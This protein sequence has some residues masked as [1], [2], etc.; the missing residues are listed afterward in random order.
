MRACRQPWMPAPGSRSRVAAIGAQAQRRRT[1]ATVIAQRRIS[2]PRRR[3]HRLPHRA[4]RQDRSPAAVPMPTPFGTLYTSNI[5]PDPQT[6]IG[7]WTADEFYQIMHNG[8]FPDGGLIYPAMPFALLHQGDA[9]GQRRDLRL[10][11]LDPAGEAEEPAARSAFPFNNRSLSSAGARCSSRRASTSPTRP[12]RR[13]G[14]AAPIWSRAS[15]IAAC[16]IPPINALGGSSESQAFEGGLIPMQNW[17]APSLTSNKE[18]GPRRLEHQGHHRLCSR[19]ASPARGAVYGPMAEVVYNSLQYLNDDDT[20]AMAVY[21]KSIA[22]GTSP[23]SRQRR[24]R[25]PRAAC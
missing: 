16:A 5:T 17:Y 9:R 24:C 20:R 3:L 11:A 8:R 14:I 2:R 10:S 12:N 6:G 7:K 15:A 13:N 18:A 23:D 4:R 25:R 19:P 22:Q 21:L 1:A